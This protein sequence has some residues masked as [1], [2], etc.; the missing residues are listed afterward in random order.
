MKRLLFS[1]IVPFVALLVLP[2]LTAA[3]LMLGS[4]VRSWDFPK[5]EPAEGEAGLF[6][7]D[8]H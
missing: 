4:W 3:L 5:T 7:P 2:W 6:I 8:L 1:D